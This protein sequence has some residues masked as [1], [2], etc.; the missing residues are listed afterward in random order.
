MEPGPYGN[1]S[2]KGPPPLSSPAQLYPALGNAMLAPWFYLPPGP[3]SNG[4]DADVSLW[5][6]INLKRHW[7]V[8]CGRKGYAYG[9]S[10]EHHSRLSLLGVYFILRRRAHPRLSLQEA[11]NATSGRWGGCVGRTRAAGA[12]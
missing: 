7:S 8:K 4:P 5:F 3:I 12:L 9:Y 11:L 2:D 6:D 10:W 1:E